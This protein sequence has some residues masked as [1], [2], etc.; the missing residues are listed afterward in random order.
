MSFFSQHKLILLLAEELVA[1]K[2]KKVESLRGGQRG[3]QRIF[4]FS[5]FFRCLMKVKLH[6][7]ILEESIFA[8]LPQVICIVVQ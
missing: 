3:K 6:V 2:K 4:L 8:R 5:N 7:C 1:K